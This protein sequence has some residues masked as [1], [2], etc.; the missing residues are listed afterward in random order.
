MITMK[1]TNKK[2]GSIR[3]WLYK[4]I[5]SRIN[6][7]AD[8][9]Q[10]H[11]SNC[12]K[13]QR[14]IASMGKVN[15]ALSLIK[16]QPHSLDLL[17]R[18]NAQAIKMLKHSLRDCPSA[19]KLKTILPEPGLFERCAKYRNPITNTAACF[20]IL[21]LMKAYVFSSMSSCRDQGQKTLKHYYATQ[22]GQ[23]IA[24]EIFPT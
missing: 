3:G 11:I 10:N 17:M 19:E 21:F 12:P 9:I 6:F 13:C 15:L 23:D 16:S 14:R 2:C 4:A 5:S 20:A 24:D 8:W 1:D 18:A 22:A 7:E